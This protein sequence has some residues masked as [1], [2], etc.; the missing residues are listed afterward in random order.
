MLNLLYHFVQ[1]RDF[2]LQGEFYFGPIPHQDHFGQDQQTLTI[3][4]VLL[5][6]CCQRVHPPDIMPPKR[7]KSIVVPQNKW[8]RE[9]VQTELDAGP[10]AKR[11]CSSEADPEIFMTI[12]QP[13]N[14]SKAKKDKSRSKNTPAQSR[15]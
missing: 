9:V 10:L 14:N 5:D 7:V 3:A 8:A 4:P 13:V 15:V 2:A 12:T 6:Q 1:R 11:T